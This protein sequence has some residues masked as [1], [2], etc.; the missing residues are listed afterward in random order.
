VF[1]SDAPFDP[2]GGRM[3]VRETIRILD[4]L[5]LTPSERHAIYEGNLRRLCGARLGRSR[6]AETARAR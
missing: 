5:E 2:E 6:Q 3:Y 1:A 4:A